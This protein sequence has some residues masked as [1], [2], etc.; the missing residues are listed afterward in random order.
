MSEVKHTPGPWKQVELA[1]NILLIQPEQAEIDGL[2]ICSVESNWDVMPAGRRADAQLI[3]AAP[4]LLAAEI[5]QEEA[6]DFYHNDCPDRDDHDEESLPELCEHCF[7]YFDKA[8]CMRRAA[9]A[10]ASISSKKEVRSAR[11]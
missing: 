11:V 2:T 1:T 7:P 4:D 3:A 8:R 6:E 10:K 5:A 9:I